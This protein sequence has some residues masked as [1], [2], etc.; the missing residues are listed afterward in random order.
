MESPAGVYQSWWNY[1]ASQPFPLLCRPRAE[2][3]IY[4]TSLRAVRFAH[5][6]AI[7]RTKEVPQARTARRQDGTTHSHVDFLNLIIGHKLL[8]SPNILVGSWTFSLLTTT[9][10]QS[11]VRLSPLFTNNLVKLRACGLT[12]ISWW[13]Q[14]SSSHNLKLVHVLYHKALWHPAWFRWCRLHTHLPQFICRLI[15]DLRILFPPPWLASCDNGTLM[16]P[17]DQNIDKT[18]D[19]GYECIIFVCRNLDNL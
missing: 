4:N 7:Q 14:F 12:P 11:V 10:S 6:S 18:I 3:G 19:H 17:F 15:L 5:W 9:V 2:I 13:W 16:G 1:A 8:L